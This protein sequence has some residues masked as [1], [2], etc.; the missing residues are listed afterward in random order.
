M[1]KSKPKPLD[2]HAT[3]IGRIVLAIARNELSV[4]D[5]VD[6]KSAHEFLQLLAEMDQE[7]EEEYVSDLADDA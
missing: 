1:G 4:D 3:N 2:A 6:H 7:T 5:W